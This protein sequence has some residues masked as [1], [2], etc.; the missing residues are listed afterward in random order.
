[1]KQLLLVGLLLMAH[2]SSEIAY[3]TTFA[4]ITYQNDVKTD[5]FAVLRLKCNT[6]HALKR[7]V[8]V[9]TYENMDSLSNAIN[10]QVFIKQKMPKG[11]INR[12][13]NLEDENLQR[14]LETLKK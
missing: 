14:W 12:L 8:L 9:F 3:S 10:E 5:A 11:R 4:D 1:M 6:C 2:Q 13:T 7:K